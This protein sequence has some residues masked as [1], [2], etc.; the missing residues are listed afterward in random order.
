MG[1]MKYMYESIKSYFSDEVKNNRR[2]M[3]DTIDY[4]PE[5]FVIDIEEATLQNNA[6]RRAL[7]TGNNLQLTLMSIPR[8]NEI[9]LEIH[10]NED[11]FLRIEEGTGVVEMGYSRDRLDYQEKVSDDDVILVP[12]GVWHNIINT[13]D[14]ALKIYS[15]YAPPHHPHGT[16][17]ET[18]EDAMA[19]E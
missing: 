5:P 6:F 19:D 11:Q 8:G 15:I 7:W 14:R 2:R 12:A 3:N 16:V 9:G 10:N 17:H 1:G 13:G 4:G 18:K